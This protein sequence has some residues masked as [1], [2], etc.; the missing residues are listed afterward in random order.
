MR[1]EDHVAC[2]VDINT[3]KILIGKP[4]RKRL[5]ERPRCRWKDIR[6][7]LGEI[8]WDVVDWINLAQDRDQ[9]WAAVNMVMNL[10]V[11]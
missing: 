1:W 8:R 5:L 6:M 2:M 7:D 3:Q 11:P 10:R 4:E 9:G